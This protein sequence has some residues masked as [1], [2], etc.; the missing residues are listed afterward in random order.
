MTGRKS[1]QGKINGEKQIGLLELIMLGLGGA[2]GSGIF[3]ASGI[4]VHL[5]GPGVILVFL[6]GGIINMLVLMMLAEMGVAQP[7]S[8]SFSIYAEEY[9]GPGMGF[10]SGWIYWTSGI[11]TLAA[12]MVAAAMIVRWWL[13]SWPIWSLSLVVALIITGVS[14]LDVR[15]FAR[16][17]EWLSF[18]KVGVLVLVI[19]LGA[20]LL[21][22]LWPGYKSPG[23]TNYVAQGGLFP[24]GWRGILTSLLLVMFTYAGGQ[25]IGLAMGD[26]RDPAKTVPKAV[27]AINFTLLFLY[28]GSITMLTGL[29]PWSTVPQDGSGFVPFFQLLGVPG[30][31]GIM[32]AVILSAVLSAMN[33]N[34]YGVPRMLNSLANRHEAPAFLAKHDRRGIPVAAVLASM[35]FLLLVAG[36]SFLLPQQIFV[37]IASASGVTILLNWLLIAVTHLRFRLHPRFTQDQKLLRYPGYPYTTYSVIILLLVVLATAAL[38]HDQLVGLIAG[39]IIFAIYTGLFYI[40]RHVDS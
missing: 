37:Y 18:I 19:V 35:A 28:I 5:A 7:V 8:G 17:E 26:T 15:A 40:V 2:I 38:N 34:M 4:P 20:V 23:I 14:L 22:G 3:V 30:V 1:R 16:L 10:V 32:N 13:P 25:V 33:S 12:E 24:N 36:M 29:I 31:A 27:M 21:T 11:L 9:L 39:L 6:T